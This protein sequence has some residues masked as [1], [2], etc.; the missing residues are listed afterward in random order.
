MAQFAY[1]FVDWTESDFTLETLNAW[2]E[3]GWKLVSNIVVYKDKRDVNEM[4]F[5]CQLDRDVK[6]QYYIENFAKAD[7]TKERFNEWGANGW[8]LVSNELA[9]VRGDVE[10]NDVNRVVFVSEIVSEAQQG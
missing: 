1:E 6:Y 10:D 3:L 2:G 8:E 7:M 9:V 4:I 5:Q